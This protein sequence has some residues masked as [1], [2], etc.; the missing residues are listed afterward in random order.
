MV[1]AGSNVCGTQNHV[2]L[3]S[4]SP[5]GV[6]FASRSIWNRSPLNFS[7][8]QRPLESTSRSNTPR[9]GVGDSTLFSNLIDG[10][11]DFPV[12]FSQ[13]FSGQDVG[14]FGLGVH[15]VDGFEVLA[16]FQLYSAF[17]LDLAVTVT[18]SIEKSPSG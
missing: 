4:M 17:S 7:T 12:D 14:Q 6:A 8:D 1:R 16:Q 13:D 11:D 18:F 5:L 10:S 3:S 2:A 9:C 15:A